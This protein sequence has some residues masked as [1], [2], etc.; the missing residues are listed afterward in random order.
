ELLGGKTLR[1][2][3]QEFDNRPAST[4]PQGGEFR[5]WPRNNGMLPAS[6]SQERVWFVQ[7]I[8]PS[9]LAYHFTAKV[10]LLG[11]LNIAALATALTAII[12]RHEIY[13]TT[14]TEIDGSLFQK[15][16]E[17]C[18][19]DLDVVNTGGQIENLEQ[20]VADESHRPF[21]LTSLPLV[22]WKLIRMRSRE[23][24]LPAVQTYKGDVPRMEISEL[25]YSDLV[26]QCRHSH[27]TMF[28]LF[29]AAFQ[30]VLFR[31]SG[32]RDFCIGTGI[33]NRRWSETSGLIGMLVNNL[34]LRLQT[35]GNPAVA[36]V[37]EGVKQTALEAYARQDVPF[38]KVVQA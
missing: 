25:L 5:K 29:A 12:A 32:Q 3:A 26:A 10:A 37:L 33:A 34:A 8:D 17:P 6:Y 22:R 23:H 11:D 27:S 21:D 9:N 36:E 18:R 20:V 14:L 30:I 4:L 1:Q 7:R 38:D 28:M 31:Y 24:V 15:I 16:H 35:G 13:R 2:I 19:V